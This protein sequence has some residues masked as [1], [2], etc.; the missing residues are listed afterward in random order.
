MR[1]L[2]QGFYHIKKSEVLPILFALSEF[3]ASMIY[4][5]FQK[6][7]LRALG[8][9]PWETYEAEYAFYGGLLLFHSF[10]LTLPLITLCGSDKIYCKILITL[11]LLIS[12]P[13]N[14]LPLFA[15]FWP[16][17]ILHSIVV[18]LA[19]LSIVAIWHPKTS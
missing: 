4:Y 13:L 1:R 15:P 2:A 11:V 8:Y 5:F 10:F 3:L 7:V 6:P 14:F 12:I 9:P 17:R 19:V 16:G 18:G